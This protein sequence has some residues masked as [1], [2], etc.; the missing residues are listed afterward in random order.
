[1]K[2]PY[3]VMILISAD[4]SL[5][6]DFLLCILRQRHECAFDVPFI[7]FELDGITRPG[8]ANLDLVG[9]A[10]ELAGRGEAFPGT[11]DHRLDAQPI[12]LSTDAQDPLADGNK[13]DRCC[14]G[15]P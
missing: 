7:N 2:W 1:S 8:S 13:V 6:R 12:Q 10:A 9:N 4:C 3:V 5:Y 14:P 15:Q 11:G